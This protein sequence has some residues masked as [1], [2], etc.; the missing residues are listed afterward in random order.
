MERPQKKQSKEVSR[1]EMLRDPDRTVSQVETPASW[2]AFQEGLDRIVGS[3]AVA[4]VPGLGSTKRRRR[5]IDG[6]LPPNVADVLLLPPETEAETGTENQPGDTLADAGQR[7]MPPGLADFFY[8]E[9]GQKSY[10][11]IPLTFRPDPDPALESQPHGPAQAAYLAGRP[12]ATLKH[13]QA[14]AEAVGEAQ[15]EAQAQAVGLT[16]ASGAADW[17]PLFT[18]WIGR[19]ASRR[20]WCASLGVPYN[21][22]YNWT[23]ADRMSLPSARIIGKLLDRALAAQNSPG[24]ADRMSTEDLQV[25]MRLHVMPKQR[26]GL[27]SPTMTRKTAAA[28]LANGPMR[29]SRMEAY[30]EGT[31]AVLG[32]GGL[33]DRRVTLPRPSTSKFMPAITPLVLVE[34][35]RAVSVMIIAH[36]S[37]YAAGLSLGMRPEILSAFVQGKSIPGRPT[38]MALTTWAYQQGKDGGGGGGREA[39]RYARY[40]QP[41]SVMARA[42]RK[43]G[44]I[45][46]VWQK[47]L[48]LWAKVK[49]EEGL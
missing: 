2:R 39:A 3:V 13:A 6:V 8:T 47:A 37:A 46:D 41:L 16:P 7:P 20:A 11:E 15:E 31:A 5:N 28:G 45:K 25:L 30:G 22:S 14:D 35:L 9:E 29:Q 32:G 36:G 48:R 42:R 18:A 40:V 19:Y 43:R 21:S 12:A 26:R 33:V 23:R 1:A 24:S 49:A 17:A 27:E 10:W 38:F 4:P 44:E 34:C